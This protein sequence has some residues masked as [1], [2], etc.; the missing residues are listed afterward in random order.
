MIRERLFD[1]GK[2]TIN[3]AEGPPSG[4]PLVLIHGLP[5]LWQ[6]FLSI[7]PALAIRWHIY[8]LDL[9]GQGRSG[10]TPGQYHS[11]YYADDVQAFLETLDEPAVVF[12]MSAGGMIGMGTAWQ[13][14]DRVRALIIGDSPIDPAW[15]IDWMSSDTMI[16]VFKTWR[17]LARLAL[18]PMEL[19]KKIA[20]LQ[21]GDTAQHLP[22]AT[23]LY[24]LDPDVLMYHAER[25]AREYLEG[26]DPDVLLPAITCPMLLLQANPEL[27]G[28]M[29]DHAVQ[30][31]LAKAHSALHVRL[32][33]YG[34]SLGMDTW[35]IGP[36]LSAVN[37]FLEAL[38]PVKE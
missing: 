18:P 34:H 32:P 1:T 37:G 9:R 30:A 23:T 12:G 2:V 36:L 11:T 31:V 21:G 33:H 10:R 7:I 38:G 14:P 27:G 4:P 20:D 6:E 22:Q 25:R 15:L 35:E 16:S 8:A 26:F 28:M 13:A 5:G 24:Y 17:D 29:T 19:A 3:V